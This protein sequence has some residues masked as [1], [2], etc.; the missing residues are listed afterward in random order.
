M[1]LSTIMPVLGQVAPISL[2]KPIDVTNFVGE[3]S[4]FSYD[5]AT[6]IM[7]VV[8]WILSVFGLEHNSTVVTF[9]YAVVVFG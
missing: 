3:K 5:L 6:F 9:F 1:I 2:T 4:G 7:K 8:D